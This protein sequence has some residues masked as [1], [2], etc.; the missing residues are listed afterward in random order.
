VEQELEAL[1]AT[2]MREPVGRE[3]WHVASQVDPVTAIVLSV[4][5]V[6]VELKRLLRAFVPEAEWLLVNLLRNPSCE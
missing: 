3:I 2:K 6:E 1:A 4:M 5:A